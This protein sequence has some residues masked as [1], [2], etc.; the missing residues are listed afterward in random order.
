MNMHAKSVDSFALNTK[1]LALLNKIKTSKGALSIENVEALLDD[2]KRVGQMQFLSTVK[3]A[4]QPKEVKPKIKK[5]EELVRLEELKRYAALKPNTF[6]SLVLE[7]A[8]EQGL[9]LP[10]LAAKDRT[11]PRLL[12]HF[13]AHSSNTELFRVGQ[14]VAEKHTRTH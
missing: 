9:K 10:K 14:L 2:Y 12:A 3:C 11:L 8:E 6:V 5:D 1:T 4:L 7:K 13:R